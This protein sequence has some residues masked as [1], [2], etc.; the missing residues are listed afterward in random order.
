MGFKHASKEFVKDAPAPFWAMLFTILALGAIGLVVQV[1]EAAPYTP[2]DRQC[3]KA[4][5]WGPAPDSVRPCV[6]LTG[7]SPELGAVQFA[8][9]DASGVVRYQGFINTPYHHV[10]A[11]Y[12]VRLYEDGS[13]RYCASNYAR[14]LTCGGV[15]N[16][17]D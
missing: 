9:S 13:F 1:A 3:F 10:A 6:K 12:I 14:R 5:E 8:V 7:N 15:G 4:S 11:V 2:T 16:L 17:Q